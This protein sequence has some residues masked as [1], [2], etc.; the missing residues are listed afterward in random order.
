MRGEPR[1]LTTGT[2]SHTKVLCTDKEG[3]VGACHQYEIMKSETSLS[4]P[5]TVIQFQK[6]GVEEVGEVNGI[7]MEDLLVIVQDRL[8]YFQVGP[9]P[10]DTNQRALECI[11]EALESLGA[12]TRD[13]QSRNVEG[14]S[15]A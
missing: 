6:G 5:L 9:F 3:P 14:R 10:C 8:E 11:Q 13:R 12:R 2:Q 7:F 4:L 15:V 1:T